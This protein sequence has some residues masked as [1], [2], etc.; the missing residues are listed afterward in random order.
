MHNASALSDQIG[1]GLHSRIT[2]SKKED[3]PYYNTLI[4]VNQPWVDLPDNPFG[5]PEIKA[6]GGGSR[7]ASVIVSIFIW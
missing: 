1:M 3:F 6:K 2:R 7:L 4:I 5:Q